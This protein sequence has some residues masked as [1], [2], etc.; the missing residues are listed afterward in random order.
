MK[1]DNE[2]LNFI[3]NNLQQVVDY[4]RSEKGMVINIAD[5]SEAE[6]N[7]IYFKAYCSIKY[8]DDNLNVAKVNGV[9]LFE[10]NEDLQYHLC[11][12]NDNTLATAINKA[13]EYV[14]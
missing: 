6:K 12:T 2:T 9:R 14:K 5:L 1:V 3:I 13:F 7:H 10:R 11:G 4:Y 8:E